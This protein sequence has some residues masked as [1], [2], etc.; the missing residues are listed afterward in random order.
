MSELIL[1]KVHITKW[2]LVVLLA[3][4]VYIIWFEYGHGVQV[5]GDSLVKATL[6]PTFNLH[7][8]LLDKSSNAQM[9]HSSGQSVD[10]LTLVLIICFLFLSMTAFVATCCENHCLVITVATLWTVLTIL[11]VATHLAASRSLLEYHYLLDI[12]LIALFWYFQSLIR[13]KGQ[14]SS[15]DF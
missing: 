14:L 6:P 8:N 4:H 7:A 2:L 11:D 5:N 15:V 9:D 13:I 12:P 3:I 1:F 10:M